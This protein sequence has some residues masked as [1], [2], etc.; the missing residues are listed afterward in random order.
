MTN[1][2]LRLPKNQLRLNFNFCF[3]FSLTYQNFNILKPFWQNKS[4]VYWHDSFKNWH[5][6]FKNWRRFDI[7]NLKFLA[8]AFNTVLHTSKSSKCQNSHH[9]PLIKKIESWTTVV[10]YR[11]ND[12][13]YFLNFI[14]WLFTKDML[15]IYFKIKLEKQMSRTYLLGS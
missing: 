9:I 11:G 6:S 4:V 13:R 10:S 8:V 3:H 1:Y 12:D 2:R 15:K 14:L 7:E 5:N